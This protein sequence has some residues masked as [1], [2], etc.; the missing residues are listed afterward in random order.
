MD[1]KTICEIV[2]WIKA[3][4]DVHEACMEDIDPS[5]PPAAIF[6]QFCASYNSI[7]PYPKNPQKTVLDGC[8]FL[9]MIGQSKGSCCG[10]PKADESNHCRFHSQV[11]FSEKVLRYL[12]NE[13]QHINLNFEEMGESFIKD[14][15]KDRKDKELQ[16][17]DGE[18]SDESSD[19][20]LPR[21]TL[22]YMSPPPV[23]NPKTVELHVRATGIPNQYR[24]IE[25]GL[26]IISGSAGKHICI[27]YS[28]SD[29]SPILPLT[30]ELKKYSGSLGLSF[31][32]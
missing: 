31:I 17:S 25:K 12:K 1:S 10:A 28:A 2:A 32:E 9:Y 24:E 19:D 15:Q 23:E 8:Q 29:D 22:Q 4:E 6:F 30:P 27:G 26:V 5:L 16:I 7:C 13:Y 3:H 21:P 20:E 18:D 11:V 14:I